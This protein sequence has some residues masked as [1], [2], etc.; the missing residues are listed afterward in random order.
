[1]EGPRVDRQ[2]EAEAFRRAAAELEVK[3]SEL[4]L[5]EARSKA[6]VEHLRGEV[7]MAEQRL[8]L[9]RQRLK[10]L[11][12]SAPV[13][14]TASLLTVERRL[15]RLEEKME[16]MLQELTPLRQQRAVAAVEEKRF[17]F[18][19]LQAKTNHKRKD[20][21]QRGRYPD[22][23]LAS[24]PGGNQTLQGITFHIGDGVMQLGSTLLPG[25]PVQ[26]A[27]IAVG[28]KLSRL[29]ILQATGFFL[30]DL[31]TPIGSYTVHYDD[32]KS[33]TIPI[34]YGMDV[35]DWWKYPNGP[36]PT[37]GKV[38]WEGEN[39]AARQFGATI[40]LY[41][42]TWENPHPAKTVTTIDYASTMDT[43]CAPFCVA[44]T[45]EQP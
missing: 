8:E 42:T 26:V 10:E 44:I 37:R 23:T 6:E 20:S 22:N 39:Q 14:G 13:P 2:Q 19:D 32:G 36:E 40:R 38:A 16:L 41:L 18:V 29:H 43:D 12:E 34:V 5:L 31:D 28:K 7:R 17:A 21:F 3:R 24:L 33:A 45:A 9:A 15:Q 27:G 35:L 4:L 25:K 1:L 30:S 11:G